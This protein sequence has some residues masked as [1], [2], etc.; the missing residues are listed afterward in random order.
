MSS[1]LGVYNKTERWWTGRPV[2]VNTEGRLLYHA[3]L[4]WMIGP[5]IGYYVLHG[6]WS[7]QNPASERNWKQFNDNDN[8]FFSISM[9]VSI[10]IISGAGKILLEDGKF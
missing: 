4:V 5:D 8:D 1:Y 3:K 10:K 6:S 2:Y 7:H 9:P